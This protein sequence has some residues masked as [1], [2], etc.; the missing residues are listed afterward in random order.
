VFALRVFDATGMEFLKN[1]IGEDYA[2]VLSTLEDRHAVI[3]GKASSCHDPVL[4]ELND[5]GEFI[6]KFRRSDV[7]TGDAEAT[8]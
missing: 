7:T 3:F 2:L 8:Q 5:R 4:V 1:Y 6:K